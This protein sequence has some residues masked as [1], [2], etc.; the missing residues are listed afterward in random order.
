MIPLIQR[1]HH[2][3]SESA[4]PSKQRSWLHGP[5]LMNLPAFLTLLHTTCKTGADCKSIQLHGAQLP[6]LAH[7]G[8]SMNEYA[9]YDLGCD[10][11]ITLLF[12]VVGALI[13]WH[14]S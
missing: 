3:P 11:V 1:H 6:A 14:K 13:F 4:L 9:L 8:F 7:A 10:M 12:L 5:T 2:V